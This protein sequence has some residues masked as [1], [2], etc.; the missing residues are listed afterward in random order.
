MSS[1]RG[2]GVLL[3]RSLRLRV[4]LATA[5]AFVGLGTVVC[6]VL[7]RA[8]AQ[9]SRDNLRERAFVLA[10]GVSYIVG[11]GVVAGE[12]G[13]GPLTGLLDA[14]PD[15]DSIVFLGPDGAVRS[16]WPESVARW[17]ATVPPGT[18]VLE[19]R[20]HFIGVSRVQGSGEVAAVA[21][22][23]STARMVT[24]L[25]SMRWLFAAIFLLTC[26]AFWVLSTYLA[27]GIVDPLEDI[28]RAAMSLADGEPRVVVP[29]SGDAEFDELSRYLDELGQKRRHSTVMASPNVVA[30]LRETSPVEKARKETPD[31]K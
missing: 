6:L 20:D 28:R 2:A 3:R 1:D 24:D 13:L 31:A 5:L 22:R 4:V 18:V 27:R 12:D 8:Y 23:L 15:F 16:H 21:V 19:G 29:R 30:Y 14:E 9:Q 10:Q 26:G 11:G 17:S 7:P 25:E